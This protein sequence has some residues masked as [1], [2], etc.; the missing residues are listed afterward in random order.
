MNIM[1]SPTDLL[2]SSKKKFT[3]GQARLRR[4]QIELMLLSL[5]G[6]L[7]DG[8]RSYLLLHG[9]TAAREDWMAMLEAL[10][11]DATRPLLAA[12]YDRLQRIANLRTQVVEGEAITLTEDSAFHSQEFACNIL[13]RYG[14]VVVVPER[15]TGQESALA[16]RASPSRPTR[17]DW[18]GA[19]QPD[20]HKRLRVLVLALL[21]IVA[22]PLIWFRLYGMP[23]PASRLSDFPAAS[24]VAAL[25]TSE[26]PAATS[27]P[28]QPFLVQRTAFVRRD[29]GGDL[30]LRAQPGDA[31]DNPIQMYIAPDTAVQIITGPVHL[32]AVDWWQVSVANQVGWCPGDVLEIR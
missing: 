10:G 12:E 11:D 8:L 17:A 1:P 29:I 16:R 7:E 14:I 21:V 18:Q 27:T 19:E 4:G 3:L 20:A 13:R 5:Y 31:L 9:H 15:D 32:D 2:N 30:A 23:A 25:A 6:S 26:P 24:G 22:V 28:P